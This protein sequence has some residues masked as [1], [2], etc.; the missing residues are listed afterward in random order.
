MFYRGF[1][2]SVQFNKS[3]VPKTIARCKYVPEMMD[4]LFQ[5]EHLQFFW[6]NQGEGERSTF[7]DRVLSNMAGQ[8]T[9]KYLPEMDNYN[10]LQLRYQ[11]RTLLF[12]DQFPR[13]IRQLGEQTVPYV[14]SSPVFLKP[15]NDRPCDIYK[16]LEISYTSATC[17]KKS[18]SSANL[19]FKLTLLG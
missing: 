17:N 6:Q 9:F 15:V 14:Q 1:L 12:Y 3:S 8:Q 5:N 16:V 2:K 19:F 18:T 7:S 10:F 11:S 4:C 13:R